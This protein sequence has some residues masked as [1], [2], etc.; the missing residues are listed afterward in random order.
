[1]HHYFWCYSYY[2]AHVVKCLHECDLHWCLANEEGKGLF[3]VLNTSHCSCL[4]H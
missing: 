3:N 1:M 4:C 2:F